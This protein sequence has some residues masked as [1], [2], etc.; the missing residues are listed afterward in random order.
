[1]PIAEVTSAEVIGILAPIWHEKAPTTRKLR[2][3][4]R[5]VLEWAVTMDLRPG[6]PC[7]RISPVF[8]AQGNA[9]RH[10][11]TLPHGNVASA[12]RA[13]NAIRLGNPMSRSHGGTKFDPVQHRFRRELAQEN[14]LK[15][16]YRRKSSLSVHV[17]R[18]LYIR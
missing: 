6:N 1:M 18:I 16:Q 4:I 11:R 2:Q 15:T 7:D 12:F 10:M 14:T 8:G 9:V 17:V 3:R 5:A 13:S